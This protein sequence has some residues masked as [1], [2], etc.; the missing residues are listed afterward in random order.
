MYSYT[1]YNVQCALYIRLIYIIITEYK[2]Y[3]Y[4]LNYIIL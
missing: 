3:Y 1:V 2:L 4:K